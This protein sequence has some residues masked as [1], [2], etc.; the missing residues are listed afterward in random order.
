MLPPS[1]DNDRII[2]EWSSTNCRRHS[3]LTCVLVS[4]LPLLPASTNWPTTSTQQANRAIWH[5]A[6]MIR[7]C[8][9]ASAT[10]I[11]PLV[12]SQYHGID[13]SIFAKATNSVA[14]L[15]VM[16]TRSPIIPG[17]TLSQHG[18]RIV[19]DRSWTDGYNIAIACQY[20]NIFRKGSHKNDRP[21]QPE[22]C[23]E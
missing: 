18:H 21:Y 12:P 14:F 10:G 23:L 2:P 3:P 16:V 8:C 22:I 5:I 17:V 7:R 1:S 20:C 4:D 15:M 6:E 9:N 11:P 13:Y 19:E